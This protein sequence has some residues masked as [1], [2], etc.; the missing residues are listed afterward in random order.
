MTRSRRTTALFS[1]QEGATLPYL[2][3]FVFCLATGLLVGPACAQD[4]YT[5]TSTGDGSD[6][7]LGDGTCE[8]SS[9]ECTL[10]AAIEEANQSSATGR[11]EFGDL[12]SGGEAVISPATP[13]P[14]I[15]QTTLIDG[16]T[17]AS[18]SAGEGPTLV[19]TGEALSEPESSGIVFFGKGA[20]GSQLRAMAVVG[21]PGDGIRVEREAHQVTI[22]D[23]YVGVGSDGETEN[24]NGGSGIWVGTNNNT[25][26]TSEG[27]TSEGGNVVS[28]N[29]KNGIEITRDSNEVKGNLVGLTAGASDSLPNGSGSSQE[30]GILVVNGSDNDISGNVSAGNDAQGIFVQG[31]SYRNSIRDNYVGTSR[32][33]VD[34]GNAYNGIRIDTEPQSKA[35]RTEVSGENVIGFN[36]RHGLYIKGHHH[37][38]ANNYIGASKG[39][40]DIGNYRHGVLLSSQSIVVGR[41]EVGGEERPG[42]MIGF[43]GLHGIRV[44]EGQDNVIRG[45][46]IGTGPDGEDLGNSEAGIEVR[47]RGG[48]ASNRNEI[49]YG[50]GQPVPDEPSPSKGNYGNVIAYNATKGIIVAGEGEVMGNAIRGNQIYSNGAEGEKRV[51]IDLGNDG[52]TENDAGDSDGGANNLQNAPKIDRGQTQYHEDTGEVELQYKVD[53]A[54]SH[55]DYGSSGLKID[56][57]LAGSEGEA[58]RY[59]HTE[60]YPES[61]A[62]S[63]RKTTFKPPSGANLSETNYIVATATDAG[64]NTSEFSAPSALSNLVKLASFEGAQ[65][66]ESKVRLEWQTTFEQGNAGFQVQ[67]RRKGGSWSKVGF[68]EGAG[69]TSQPQSYSYT[70]EDLSIGTQHFRLV[71]VG[72]NDKRRAH[73]PIT[74]HLGM[75][76]AIHLSAPAPNP[77][78]SRSRVSFAVKEEMETKVALFNVLGQKVA[79][80]YQGIP[81]AEEQ[82]TLQLD[83]TRLSSGMYY[84]HLVA[85]GRARTQRMTVVR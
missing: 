41:A 59:L 43:N 25:I 82:Q 50:F 13:L 60:R 71:Q 40:K 52:T 55:S 63:F 57:Y 69:T 10:R 15:T 85:G 79:T 77:A 17:E 20:A 74:V 39:G 23:C 49:G 1:L 38:V 16:T 64:G 42:N 44:L 4:T 67:H 14:S 54:P 61:E 5:V 8:T 84:I 70:V 32:D 58:K 21:F 12:S 80:L 6:A 3:A 56:F 29:A 76:E 26:G 27:G 81:R 53:S 45:N 35:D 28:G 48:K 34:L 11:I 73:D 22:E 31:E 30:A 62:G 7:N 51:G 2:L 36:R 78:K 19:L 37:A 75:E 66:E 72:K 9:G 65:Q 46:Y 18:Y 47:S 68:V 83:A 24:E 33:L